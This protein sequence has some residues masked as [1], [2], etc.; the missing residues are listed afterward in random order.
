MDESSAAQTPASD[1]TP[2]RSDSE[3]PRDDG[4]PKIS[5]DDFFKVELRVGRVV[6]AEAVPKSR[7]LVK[8]Q[9]DT[10]EG[11]RQVLAGILAAYEPESLVGK[12]VVFVANLKPA[13]IRGVESQG[14]LLAASKGESLKLITVD[15][16]LSSGASVQ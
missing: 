10:G 14:M 15:G 8:L 4:E 5:I 13:K 6:A 1:A 2:P 16:E 11:E 7:K 9:L 12:S 3:A